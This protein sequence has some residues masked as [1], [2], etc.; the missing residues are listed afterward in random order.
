[1]TDTMKNPPGAILVLHGRVVAAAGEARATARQML[2]GTQAT[3]ALIDQ[4]S[5]RAANGDSFSAGEFA[6]LCQTFFKA[7]DATI[8]H[9]DAMERWTELSQELHRVQAAQLERLTAQLRRKGHGR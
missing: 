3:R 2:E 4:L 7:T 9:A 1:M 6:R 5:V 8:N